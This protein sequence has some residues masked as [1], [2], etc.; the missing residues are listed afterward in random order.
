MKKYELLAPVGDF[1]SLRAAVDSGAD[2]VYFGIRGFN[3]RNPSDFVASSGNKVSLSVRF[4]VR[5]EQSFFEFANLR[6]AVSGLGGGCYE[7]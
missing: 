2:A 5:T 3:M 7:K 4:A 6:F 1:R